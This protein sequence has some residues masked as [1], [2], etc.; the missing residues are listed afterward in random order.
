[1][2]TSTGTTTGTTTGSDPADEALKAKHRA[3]WASGD[4]A[5]IGA[6]L[7][8][9]LGHRLVEALAIRPGE[10]VLDVAA[11]N[12]NASL[13]AAAAGARVVASDLTPELLEAGRR[14]GEAAGLDLRWEQADVEQLP[15][16]DASF[17]VVMS[18]IG[19]MFAPRHQRSADEMLRVLR[20]GGRLGVLSWTAAGVV[21]G[22]LAAMKPWMA[23]PPP[24]ASPGLLWGD[25]EHVRGLLGDR[26]DQVSMATETFNVD[27]FPGATDLRTFFAAKYGPTI[28]AYRTAG[29]AHRA[30]LDAAI[31]DVWERY[32]NADGTM[33]W[34]YAVLTASRH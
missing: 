22:L 10:E 16:A 29:E 4:Y 21:G 3:M 34:E 7:V 26:A 23:P 8:A 11:G 20:P 9:P 24:G 27:L 31:D 18:C 33:D 1:M 2:S 12:G 25:E 14:R 17:D 19:V 30:E 32:R 28:A 6:G 15:F 13:P 5:E